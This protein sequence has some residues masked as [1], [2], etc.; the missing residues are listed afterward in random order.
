MIK[1]VLEKKKQAEKK[2]DGMEEGLQ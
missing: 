1:K 2:E